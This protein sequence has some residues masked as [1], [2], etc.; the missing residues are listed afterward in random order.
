[1]CV[2]E[3]YNRYG[4]RLLLRVDED[5]FCSVPR[6]WTDVVA[7]DPEIVLGGGR[8][9]LRLAD[10]LELAE[11]M[12]RMHQSTQSG[13]HVRKGND[14]ACVKQTTPRKRRS[15]PDVCCATVRQTKHKGRTS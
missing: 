14:A 15:A 8:A 13:S 1:M 9:L 12:T 2:G 5:S 10:F 3:R 6:Q 4:T 7:P 11:L